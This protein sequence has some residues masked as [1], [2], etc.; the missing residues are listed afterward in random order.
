MFKCFLAFIFLLQPRNS[1]WGLKK[2]VLENSWNR[3]EKSTIVRFP[4]WSFPAKWN[5]VPAARK[6]LSDLLGAWWKFCIWRMPRGEHRVPCLLCGPCLPLM[7]TPACEQHPHVVG[8]SVLH[9]QSLRV[10]R[11]ASHH[12]GLNITTVKSTVVETTEP[13]FY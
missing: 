1:G 11:S 5:P 6:C 3:S 13:S 9:R 2:E 10:S 8:G 4:L 7:T 12:Q